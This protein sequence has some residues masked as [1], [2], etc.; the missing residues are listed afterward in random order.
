MLCTTN[1]KILEYC[2]HSLLGREMV[3]SKYFCDWGYPW[4]VLSVRRLGS[5][6]CTYF[7][8]RR[9]VVRCAFWRRKNQWGV[10]FA[11]WLGSDGTKMCCETPF[12][13]LASNSV[14][15]ALTNTRST[16]DTFFLVYHM[17]LLNLTWNCINRTISFT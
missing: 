7:P 1:L 13:V 3:L 10:L 17:S 14:E 2:T 12:V 11:R 15:W 6:H 8:L 16:F 5:D 4:G 9:E